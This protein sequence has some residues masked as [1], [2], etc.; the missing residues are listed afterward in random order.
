MQDNMNPM[1]A[2][3]NTLQQLSPEL[4]SK[5]KPHI[6]EIVKEMNKRELSEET[7]NAV[8]DEL[9]YSLLQSQNITLEDEFAVPTFNGIRSLYRSN[10]YWNPYHLG[11]RNSRG[12]PTDTL[13]RLLLLRDL[14]YWSF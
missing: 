2:N 9:I 6:E 10:P 14:G 3:Q 4:Y 5:I 8:I 13:I 12:M 11:W 1:A 7:L